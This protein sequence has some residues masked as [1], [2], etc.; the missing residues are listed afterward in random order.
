LVSRVKT[1]WT[2][3]TTTTTQALLEY[4]GNMWMRIH[5]TLEEYGIDT[6]LANSFKTKTIA[7]AKIK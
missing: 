4:T 2:H 3:S 5:D 1:N 7:E 6:L